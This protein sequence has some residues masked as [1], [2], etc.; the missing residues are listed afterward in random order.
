[1]N[2]MK[3]KSS[4]KVLAQLLALLL[5]VGAYQVHAQ[6]STNKAG[7][8]NKAAAPN[9]PAELTACSPELVG[10]SAE[11]LERL[12]A[13]MHETV[14]Q[15]Q[16]SGVVTILAR[17]GKGV[18]H[19]AYGTKDMATG[20]PMTL[21]A[22]FRDYSM[23]K[24]VTAV[25]MMILYEQGKW[26]P[27]DRISKFIPEFRDLKVFK[28]VSDEAERVV[29]DPVHRPTMQEWLTHTAGFAYGFFGSPVDKMYRD[30]QVLG[31]KDLKQMVEKLAK[32]PLAYQP[33]KGWAYSVSMNIQ[34]YI[35]EKLSGQ[36]LPDFMEQHIFKP[37]GM[38]DAGFFVP[39]E[40]R[41][42]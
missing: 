2:K 34:G 39:K 9:K 40:K 35:I 24:P 22:I 19:R 21:D 29:Q 12:H 30:Q 13:L 4:I 33:G 1:M 16:V 8:S 3:T 6:R 26:L 36:S 10:F 32:I 20:A 18:D 7:A 17:H 31:S 25:A 28:Y 15:K 38:K 37:L 42:R 14:D 41:S 5:A 23:T 27:T 11:R